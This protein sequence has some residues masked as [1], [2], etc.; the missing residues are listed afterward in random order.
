MVGQTAAA[1]A[2]AAR[3]VGGLTVQTEGLRDLVAQMKQ[4]WGFSE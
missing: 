3:A 4:G 2:E 1:M